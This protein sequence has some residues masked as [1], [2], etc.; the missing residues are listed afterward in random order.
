MKFACLSKQRNEI[1]IVDVFDKRLDL[2]LPTQERINCLAFHPNGKILAAGSELSGIF[3]WDLLSGNSLGF[4][5]TGYKVAT[6]FTVREIKFRP[7]S[8]DLAVLG[9][10]KGYVLFFN[11]HSRKPGLRIKNHSLP[12]LCMEFT[13]DGRRLIMGSEDCRVSV[14]DADSGQ[15][16][17]VLNDCLNPI[18]HLAISSNGQ[19]LA[20]VETGLD[21]NSNWLSRIMIWNHKTDR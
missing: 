4:I 2:T 17:L 8:D 16:L 5:D 19:E 18:T 21:S 20:A 9:V 3:L 15:E 13:P 12:V 7:D 10:D 1:F 11:M 6:D 14:S